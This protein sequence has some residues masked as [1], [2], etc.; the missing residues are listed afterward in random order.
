[1]SLVVFLGIAIVLGVILHRYSRTIFLPS[2]LSGIGSSAGFHL[3]GLII[4]G[5]LDSLVLI[6]MVVAFLF[7]FAIALAIGALMRH[8][9][10]KLG[11][12]NRA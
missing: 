5:A 2:L 6:S 1:M 7:A 9:G 11:G 8:S 10:R 12:N 3:I 4:E